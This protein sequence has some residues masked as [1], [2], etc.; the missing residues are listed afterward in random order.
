MGSNLRMPNINRVEFA[1]RL[2]R[3]AEFRATQAG[4]EFAKLQVAVSRKY[5]GK[6]ET[7]WASVMLF[8]KSIEWLKPDLRKGRAVYV[9]G[10]LSQYKDKDGKTNHTQIMADDVQMIDWNDDAPTQRPAQHDDAPVAPSYGPP[11][12]DDI[13]F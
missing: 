8:G 6:E 7:Y 13:P 4:A 10:R 3:D 9:V 5:K 12:D 2:V 11:D 1:G